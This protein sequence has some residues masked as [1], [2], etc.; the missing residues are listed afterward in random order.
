MKKVLVTGATGFLGS[1][2]LAELKGKYQIV[3]VG[4]NKEKLR[5]IKKESSSTECIAADLS[6]SGQ[7]S[8]FPQTDI[9]VHAAA[10][11][12]VWGTKKE[13]IKS[14]ITATEN[15]VSYCKEKKV[16]RL[17]Y[18]STPSVYSGKKNRFDVR[19]DEFDRSNRLNYY[20]ETKIAAEKIVLDAKSDDL[21][22]VIIRP[23]G[24]IGIGD[25]SILPRIIDANSKIGIPVFKG[26]ED[27]IVDMTSVENTAYSVLLCMEKDGI[28]GEIFNITNG[29]PT[30]QKKLLEYVA[31][32]L[33]TKFRYKKLS[34]GRIYMI[35]S[36]MEGVYKFFGIKKEPIL[37][38][39][40]VCTLAFSQT[41]NIEKAEKMLGYKPRISLEDEIKRFGR[42][43]KENGS[44]K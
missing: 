1:Y 41:L 39:Y 23:K 9:V 26:N 44:V 19:E 4:R 29:E 20:I 42:F 24:L 22:V 2:I 5:K 21:E 34:F 7:V 13:F 12:T 8:E 32:S 3:S 11:S 28:S 31:E 14:N 30:N 27:I 17:V 16:K 43:Y 15:I 33:G 18:I 40:T 6:D 10:L 38:R 35:A 36:I 25:T 37:T